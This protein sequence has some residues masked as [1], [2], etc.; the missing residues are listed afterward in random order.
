LLG[1]GC[2]RNVRGHSSPRV[3]VVDGNRIEKVL[4]DT[5]HNHD[6]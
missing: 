4:A 3:C 1:T 5:A 6:L 2:I